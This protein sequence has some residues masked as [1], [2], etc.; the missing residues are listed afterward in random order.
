MSNRC[1]NSE[2]RGLRRSGREDGIVFALVQISNEKLD[3]FGVIFR[4]VNLISLRFLD[5]VN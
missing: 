2:R 5:Y 4:Q 1:N 3:R